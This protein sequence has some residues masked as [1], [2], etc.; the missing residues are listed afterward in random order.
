[1]TDNLDDTIDYTPNPEEKK[2]TPEEIENRRRA[3]EARKKA[4]ARQIE[5]RK[6]S[7]EKH[8]PAE[9]FIPPEDESDEEAKTGETPVPEAL[10]DTSAIEKILI[11]KK[12]E[13]RIMNP[14]AT[15]D[16]NLRMKDEQRPAF[17]ARLARKE[18]E[19]KE[20]GLDKKREQA[21]LYEIRIIATLLHRGV[22]NP[23]AMKA[24]CYSPD[25]DEMIFEEALEAIDSCIEG[26]K[27]I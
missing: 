26:L 1:M 10:L 12:A 23:V 20:P 22:V 13:I 24:K 3:Q 18:S 8:G 5:L 15:A 6:K 25:F 14:E 4:Q 19:L 27:P 7:T 16:P 21:L 2:E 17:E 9:E 11:H